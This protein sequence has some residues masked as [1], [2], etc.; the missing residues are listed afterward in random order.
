[1]TCFLREGRKLLLFSILWLNSVSSA[2]CKGWFTVR[3][4]SIILWPSKPK[5]F[6]PSSRSYL[7][8]QMLLP[9]SHQMEQW[10]LHARMIDFSSPPRALL[11]LSFLLSNC[12]LIYSQ[13]RCRSYGSRNWAVEGWELSQVEFGAGC[14]VWT[15]TTQSVAYG[16][17]ALAL[18][19]A[20]G[21]SRIWSTTDLRGQNLQ[22]CNMISRK[23]ICHIKVWK[24]QT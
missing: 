17:E 4:L 3:I 16:L 20:C 24:S 10:P 8:P 22:D 1:M 7:P 19:G 13:C 5:T 9:A 6:V 18:P 23:F 21:K 2:H 12:V 11:A 14:L 15:L